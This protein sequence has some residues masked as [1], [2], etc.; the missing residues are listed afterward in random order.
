MCCFTDE[1]N[2]NKIAYVQFPQSSYNITTHDLY[3]SCF[4]V[5]NELEM[6]GMDANGGPCYIGSGC[7]HRRHALRGAIYTVFFKQEWNGETTRNE[8]ESTSVLEER[9]KP[10]AS[11]TYEKNTQWG[12]DVGLLY[13]YPSEDIVTGLTMQCRGWKSVYLNP[14][15]KG[16]VGIAPT[17][18]LD[19]LVQHKRWSEGQFSILIS[20]CCPFLY[21]YKRIPFILQMAYTL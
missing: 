2:G 3:A 15:R 18:L 9:C 17:T 13:G 6:G 8:N 4:R 7:F 12:K 20:K 1:E 21:G 16:F 11:C 14:E 5:P 19:V 10:L